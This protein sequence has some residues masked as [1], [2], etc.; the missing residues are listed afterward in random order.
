VSL[1]SE[2]TKRLVFALLGATVTTFIVALVEAHA[3]WSA[4]LGSHPPGYLAL[5]LADLGV[6][7]PLAVVVGLLV[8]GVA[9]FFEPDRAHA[10]QE[11]LARL[12]AEPVLTRSR[13]AA[14]VPLGVVA[15]FAWCVATAHLAR[16]ALA[17]GAPIHSGIDIA[18]S[19]MAV[20]VGLGV[21]VLAVLPTA[22]RL[23]ARGAARRPKLTDPVA[24]GGAACALVAMALIYGAARGDTGGGGGTLQIFGVLKRGELD[25][26]PV[27]NLAAVAMGAY[28]FPIALAARASAVRLLVALVA[29]IAPLAVTMREAQ[30]MNDD[31]RMARAIEHGAPLGKVALAVLRRATDR[32]K[33]GASPYFGGG[34][35]DDHDPRRS[36]YAIEIPGNGIDE[37]CSGADLPLP[38]EWPLIT[39]PPGANSPALDPEMNLI[40]VTID[41]LRTDVGFMGYD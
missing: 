3:T 11:Y 33:D 8:G 1:V 14:L 15:A 34:D 38:V 6:L 36:P 31:P 22:R 5:V 32:D 9:L 35:C 4:L 37:D 7:A 21:L 17:E 41:T 30:A 10:P 18:A 13:T 2:W 25:L 28:L 40:L 12:R 20:L 16:A 39:R 23:I 27:V 26:R 19:S 24:T 29:T